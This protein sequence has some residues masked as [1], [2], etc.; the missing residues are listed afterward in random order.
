MLKRE[1]RSSWL[2]RNWALLLIAAFTTAGGTPGN[3][4]NGGTNGGTGGAGLQFI[5]KLQ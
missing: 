3:G 1:A 4:A 2:T 5:Y